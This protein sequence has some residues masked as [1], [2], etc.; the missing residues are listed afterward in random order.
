MLNLFRQN[1]LLAGI[2]LFFLHVLLRFNLLV[3][4]P[5]Y[6]FIQN[7]PLARMFF[8]FIASL[9]DPYLWSAII[10]SVLIFLQAIAINY[11]VSSQGILYRSSFMPA[12]FFLLINSFFPQQNQLTPQ[13]VSNTFILVLFQRLCYLYESQ[14]PLLVVFDAGLC[15]G[16]GILFNYDLMLF[17]PFILI[18]VVIF[19][20]FNLRYLV[21]SVLGICT[22]LY[23]TG[24]FFYVTDRLGE[25]L[26]YVQQSFEHKYLK[27]IETDWVRLLP[28]VI[29]GPVTVLSVFGLQ[30]H[31]FRN[32]V[33]TRRII[34]STYLMLV[35]GLAGLFFENVNYIYAIIYLS[36]PLSIIVAYYFISDKRFWIKELAFYALTGLAFYYQLR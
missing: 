23:F 31:F 15:L 16:V 29:I 12:L 17:L 7:A 3:S 13:L 4:P 2:M 25:L 28:W 30:Q 14:N 36:V 20:S 1:T 9:E 26:V 27:T 10:V 34:Q 22:P 11:I 21:I 35:F 33:K 24:I 32:K 5:H 19:T 18:S 8:G 6:E